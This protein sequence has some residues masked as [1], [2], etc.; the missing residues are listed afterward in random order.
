[1]MILEG[2]VST[3]YLTEDDRTKIDVAELYAR[4]HLKN[5]CERNPLCY[6]YNQLILLCQSLSESILFFSMCWH[7]VLFSPHACFIR[8]I[9]PQMQRIEEAFV[10]EARVQS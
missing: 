4:T 2:S 5:I 9:V 8:Q 6:K 3:D 7:A 1:M 10:L